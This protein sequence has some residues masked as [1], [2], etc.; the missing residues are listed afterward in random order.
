MGSGFSS[1]PVINCDIFNYDFSEYQDR[2]GTI[3]VNSFRGFSSAVEQVINDELFLKKLSKD[4]DDKA[5]HWGLTGG[6]NI[7]NHYLYNRSVGVI[8]GKC[9]I[10]NHRNK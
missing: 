8:V 9:K 4:M 5:H 1:V 6:R 2:S 3:A 10:R 7:E